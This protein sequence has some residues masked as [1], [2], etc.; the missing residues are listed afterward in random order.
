MREAG[1]IPSLGTMNESK[2]PAVF[3]IASIL[4]L[5]AAIGSFMTGAFFGLILAVTGR[6]LGIVAAVIKA[7]LWFF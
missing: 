5:V 3:S 1:I 6:V 7:F 2:K 4:S